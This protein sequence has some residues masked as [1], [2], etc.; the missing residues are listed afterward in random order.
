MLRLPALPIAS[1]PHEAEVIQALLEDGVL[2]LGF[3]K[4]SAD[5]FDT[6]LRQ[7]LRQ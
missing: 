4:W 5:A 6:A 2:R 7:M 1:A 3:L